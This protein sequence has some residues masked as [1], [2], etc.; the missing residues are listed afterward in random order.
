MYQDGWTDQ[1][2]FLESQIYLNGGPFMYLRLFE[3]GYG[4]VRSDSVLLFR[5]YHS[6][7]ESLLAAAVKQLTGTVKEIKQRLHIKSQTVHGLLP[8]A[9]HEECVKF[10]EANS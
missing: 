4:V 9:L 7:K 10:I 3:D 6:T 1:T 5:S 8:K 2:E